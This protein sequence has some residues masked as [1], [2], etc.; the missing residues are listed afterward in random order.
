MNQAVAVPKAE[1]S[2]DFLDRA[3]RMEVL[4]TDNALHGLCLLLDGEDKN[5]DF[6]AR[7]DRLRQTGTI[8]S[9]WTLSAGTPLTKGKLAYMVYQTCAI[10]E[11]GAMLAVL[12]PTQRYCLREL[13]YRGMMAPGNEST[14]VTGMEFVA[15]ITRADVYKQTGSFPNAVGQPQ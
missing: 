8:A 1:D 10:K 4:D 15:V 13:Q 11:K 7:I 12:G 2:A 14:P 5:P 3:S 6:Q 9:R